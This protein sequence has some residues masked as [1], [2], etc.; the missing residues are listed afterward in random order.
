MVLYWLPQL[1]KLL[2]ATSYPTST[3]DG[4]KEGTAWR[5]AGLRS[6]NQRP[7]V[8][9]CLHMPPDPPRTPPGGSLG[10]GCTLPLLLEAIK[11]NTFTVRSLFLTQP[12]LLMCW[13]LLE[14]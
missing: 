14:T 1:Q 12:L 6:R 5:Q 13:T 4:Q 8:K 9:V 2:L 7:C 10:R 11:F 3:S